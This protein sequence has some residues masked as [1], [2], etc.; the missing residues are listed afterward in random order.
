MFTLHS[1]NKGRR[2]GTIRTPHGS[3]STPAFMPIATRGAVKHLAPAEL[4]KI[5]AEII[6]SNTYHL[7]QRP[8]LEVLKEQKGLHRLMGW[9]GP[10]L[11]DSGGYQ[12]FS[13]SK[14][15]KLSDDGVTFRS[16]IDGSRIHLT[17]ESV[18]DIQLTIGS[19]IIM[20]LDECPPWPCDRQYASK[21]LDL[22]LSWAERSKRHFEKMMV[23]TKIP[24]AKRPLLFGI[25]QGSTYKDL[26][27][28]SA[29]ALVQIGFDGYAIGGLAV[30]EPASKRL[31]SLEWSVEHLPTD[32]PRYMMG[33]GKPEDIVAA[34]KRGV[35]M[36]DCVIPTREARHGRLYVS[37]NKPSEK[38][39]YSA[40][41]IKGEAFKNDSRPI[42]SKCA[43]L[44]CASPSRAYLRHL[45]SVGEPLAARYAT[46]HNL[47][48]Y[49]NLMR[50]LRE[51]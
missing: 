50:S 7:F 20:V 30:G 6:L 34:V 17:P 37:K 12:V 27:R 36:F 49:Q 11:T 33:V 39:F 21:S 24:P 19:D 28:K 16:E 40:V 42:D 2:V 4:K 5:G 45:F 46:I 18:I 51:K 41:N 38:V 25:V 1:T 43:C 14:M 9:N 23:R 44:A 31:K 47:T 35:D 13:L 48:F 8:G 10:I 29:Q 3:F 15:R 32:K 22:T 26:R